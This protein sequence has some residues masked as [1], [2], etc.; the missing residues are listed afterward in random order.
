MFTLH[1][2]FADMLQNIFGTSHTGRVAMS[3]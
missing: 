2:V 1:K 3:N